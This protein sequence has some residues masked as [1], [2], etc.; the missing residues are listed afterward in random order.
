MRPGL[1]SLVGA[2]VFATLLLCGSVPLPE[3]APSASTK[4]GT[5]PF[6]TPTAFTP[7]LRVNSVHF[8]FDHQVEPTLVVDGAGRLYVGWKEALTHNGGGQRVGFST[9]GDDGAT[10]SPNILMDLV[11]GPRQS[12]PW[13]ALAPNGTVYFAR[14]EYD[15]LAY[16]TNNTSGISVSATTGGAAWGPTY[17]LNDTPNFADKETLAMGPDGALNMVFNTDTPTDGDLVFVRSTDGGATWTPKVRVPDA[18]GGVIGGNV[19]VLPSGDL[20]VAWF[21]YTEQ[22]L[23]AD[24]STDGGVTWGPDVR[25]NDVYGSGVWSNWILSMPSMSVGPN[26]TVYLAWTD[27]RDGDPDAYLAA[28]W[29]GGATWTADVRMD[30]DPGTA[31]QFQAELAVDPWGR[32]HAAWYDG[33][34]G[35]LN[36]GYARSSDGGATW[37]PSVFVTDAET[38]ISYDRPGDYFAMES[39]PDGTIYAAWT[40]GRGPDLDIY[41]SKLPPAARVTVEGDPAGA[42][43]SVDGVPV[44]T[45]ATFLWLQGTN[46]TLE[47]PELQDA[48]A[49]TRLRF[50]AWSDGAP[51]ARNLT[52]GIED[53][54]VRATFS[55]EHLLTIGTPYGNPTGG[56][57]YAAGAIATV[58]IEGSVSTAGQTV[59]FARWEGDATS[60]S[61]RTSVLMD[62]PKTLRA[63]WVVAVDGYAGSYLAYVVAGIAIALALALV[64][65]VLWIRHRGRQDE[66]RG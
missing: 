20:V 14:L 22:N 32:V 30:D 16:T 59:T 46:H 44:A 41:F 64:V 40:D 45:P 25:V 6:A 57:W 4:G 50:E 49:G 8:G 34:T 17:H 15:R 48:G 19:G 3:G 23:Y 52:A 51:R 43:V 47:V 2:V 12:D 1:L 58:G 62:G 33:R 42:L 5:R 11:E 36:L 28:S 7:N 18:P 55:T 65:V 9:S 63:T 27:D 10:W 39:G 60:T 38:P 26:G 53:R 13:L 31:P 35:D 37:S 54:I 56:G 24:R 61:N 29:D 66:K 21:N